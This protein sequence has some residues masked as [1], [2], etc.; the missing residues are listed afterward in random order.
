MGAKEVT[1]AE[2]LSGRKMFAAY[3]RPDATTPIKQTR[4]IMANK[5]CTLAAH[6]VH[7]AEHSP[8]C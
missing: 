6:V 3:V 2:E 8:T 7:A 4:I 1:I 5:H